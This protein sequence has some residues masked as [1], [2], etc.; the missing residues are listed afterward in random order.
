MDFNIAHFNMVARQVQTWDVLDPNILALLETT[1]RELFT[2]GAFQALAS[3]DTF[4][5]IGY[6]QV[7]LPPKMVGRILQALD[8]EKH[9]VILEI[10]TGTGYMTALLSQL[11][12]HVV[13]IEIIA[14]LLDQARHFLIELNCHNITLEVGNGAYGFES[15]NPYNAII[16]T[17][18]L[19]YLPKVLREQLAINGRLFAV[20]GE[21]PAMSAVLLTRV[22]KDRWREKVLFET[23]IPPLLQAP[24]INGFKF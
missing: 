23:V 19:P 15:R 1:P 17:G 6:D 21:A 24:T 12:K 8:L 18:S 2:P 5:P 4:I 20:V 9:E 16:F 7:M 14:P 3:S 22:S 10:G 11:V 13:S